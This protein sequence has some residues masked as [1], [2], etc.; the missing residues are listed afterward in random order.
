MSKKNVFNTQVLGHY[1][2][3]GAVCLSTVHIL[4]NVFQKF[5]IFNAV[6]TLK[7]RKNK[8]DKFQLSSNTL[9]RKVC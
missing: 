8:K 1:D 5:K 3:E 6:Q 4:I 7:K 2:K 9:P